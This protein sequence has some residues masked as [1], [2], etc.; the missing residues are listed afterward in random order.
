PV[1]PVPVVEQADPADR[2][3]QGTRVTGPGAAH[4]ALC[5]RGVPGEPEGAQRGGGHGGA[6]AGHECATQHV[7]L[8][9]VVVR[10]VAVVR[11]V[12][13]PRLLI[14]IRGPAGLT[15]GVRRGRCGHR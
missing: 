13:V 10:V 9:V 1:G 3:L 12:R 15:R 2:L 6:P 5:G 14:R 7:A 11:V 8:L 4:G